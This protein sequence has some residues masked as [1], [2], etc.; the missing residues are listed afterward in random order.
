VAGIQYIPV[1]KS[2][3]TQFGGFD[4]DWVKS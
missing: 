2:I 1:N 4:C 3:L